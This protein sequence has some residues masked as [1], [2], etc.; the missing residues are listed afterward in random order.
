MKTLKAG[1]CVGLRKSVRQNA[2]K[3]VLHGSSKPANFAGSLTGPYVKAW[4]IVTG[5]KK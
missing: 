5:K 4:Y 2:E 1:K 3:I